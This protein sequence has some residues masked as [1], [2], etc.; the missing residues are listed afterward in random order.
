MVSGVLNTTLAIFTAAIQ[1]RWGPTLLIFMFDFLKAL[2]FLEFMVVF[3]V[4]ALKRDMSR[5]SDDLV[6]AGIRI[7]LIWGIF[8]NSQLWGQA[9]IDAGTAIGGAITTGS[10]GTLTPTGVFHQGLELASI[11]WYA[12]GA[13]TFLHPIQDIEFFIAALTVM[14]AWLIAALVLLETL[15]EA[16][17]LVYGGSILIAFAPFHYTAELVVTWGKAVFAIAIKTAVLLGLLGIGMAVAQIW[18]VQVQDLSATF[19]TNIFNLLEAVVMAI[20]LLYLIWKVIHLFTGLIGYS[21]ALQFGSAFGSLVMSSGAQAVASKAQRAAS[22]VA[23][24]AGGL[25]G[26]GAKM[27]GQAAKAAGQAVMAAVLKI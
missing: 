5:L 16:V 9:V 10:P 22:T 21:P 26:E 13:G 1:D 12:K 2:T 23:S 14:L 7:G 20:L 8:S 3:M 6:I 18:A 27:A 19:T 11:L 25:I 4:A 15:L 24:E 17:I